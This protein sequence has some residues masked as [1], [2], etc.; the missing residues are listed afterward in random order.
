MAA[1]AQAMQV[2][3]GGDVGGNNEWSRGSDLAMQKAL[4]Q[5]ELLPQSHHRRIYTSRN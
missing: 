4:E 2:A 1:A 5:A 3:A